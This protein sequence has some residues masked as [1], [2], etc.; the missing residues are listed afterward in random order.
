VRD[1]AL[2]LEVIAGYDMRD[3]PV[4]Q[5]RRDVSMSPRIA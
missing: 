3:A 5:L 4:F 2:L 1:V